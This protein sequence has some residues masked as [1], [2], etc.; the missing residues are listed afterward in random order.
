MYGEEDH[1]RF[2]KYYPLLEVFEQFLEA[3]ENAQE[4]RL[5]NAIR[6]DEFS[7]DETTP[8]TVPELAE[9]FKRDKRTVRAWLESSGEEPQGKSGNA[10]L[11][12]RAQV[13]IAMRHE[14]DSE[15]TEPSKTRR[16]GKKNSLGT[17]V[18]RHR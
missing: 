4:I 12:S 17:S 2:Q 10:L 13:R 15:Q 11:F 6:E 5:L 16:S 18:T 1:K 8:H 9:F 14:L 3:R 7:I